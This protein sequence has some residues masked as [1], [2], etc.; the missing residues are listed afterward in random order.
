MKNKGTFAQQL[1]QLFGKPKKPQFT[2]QPK[3]P[4]TEDKNDQPSPTSKP[5]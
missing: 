5:I 4:T 1:E 3:Q 2:E